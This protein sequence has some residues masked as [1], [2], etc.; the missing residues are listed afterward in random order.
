MAK[1]FAANFRAIW[2]FVSTR[3]EAAKLFDVSNASFSGFLATGQE[4]MR[5]PPNH[6]MQSFVRDRGSANL[7]RHFAQ[8]SIL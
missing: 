6:I 8:S 5:T 2:E 4:L 3:V 1:L 7:R